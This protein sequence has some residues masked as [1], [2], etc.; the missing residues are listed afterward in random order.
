MNNFFNKKKYW[1]KLV[2]ISVAFFFTVNNFTFALEARPADTL[3]PVS[4]VNPMI[5]LVEEDGILRLVKDTSKRLKPTQA[6]QE[7]W[8]FFYLS[9]YIGQILENYGSEI[10]AKK[11][12]KELEKHISHVEFKRFKWQEITKE[13]KTFRLP[14]RTSSSKKDRHPFLRFYLASDEPRE[15]LGKVSMPIGDTVRMTCENYTL[16]EMYL[17]KL[18]NAIEKN[19]TVE[20]KTGK[21]TSIESYGK[22]AD[23]M[24]PEE[25]EA[26]PPRAFLDKK[27][28]IIATLLPVIYL[29]F[30]FSPQAALTKTIT[31]VLPVVAVSIAIHEFFHWIRI[32]VLKRQNQKIR[33]KPV[34]SK[35]GFYFDLFTDR[36]S[37]A[38]K[39]IQAGMEASGLISTV[40]SVLSLFLSP[41]FIIIMGIVNVV[42]AS[43]ARDRKELRKNVDFVEAH[44]RFYKKVR[45]VRR[46]KAFRKAEKPLLILLGGYFSS[47]KGL[48]SD[49]LKR[50]IERKTKSKV[51]IIGGDN[52]LWREGRRSTE[53]AYPYDKYEVDRWKD[54]VKRLKEGKTAYI[55]YYLSMFGRRLNVRKKDLDEIKS[56]ASVFQRSGYNL[57]YADFVRKMPIGNFLPDRHISAK[58]ARVMDVWKDN[59]EALKQIISLWRETLKRP[60]EEFLI[61]KR[62]RI[63]IDADTGDILEAFTP[64]KEDVLIVEFEQALKYEEIRDQ[65][66]ISGFVEASPL[67]RR[68]FFMARRRSGKRYTKLT[69]E[70]AEEKF[71]MLFA[72]EDQLFTQKGYADLIVKNDV[73]L[74]KK[75]LDFEDEE[76]KLEEEEKTPENLILNLKNS[77]IELFISL[78]PGAEEFKEIFK[79]NEERAIAQFK[80]LFK[81]LKR[82]TQK[83]RKVSMATFEDGA[84]GMTFFVQVSNYSKEKDICEAS[85]HVLDHEIANLFGMPLLEKT[86]K[87]TQVASVQAIRDKYADKEDTSIFD[88]V[89]RLKKQ[90]FKT[91]LIYDNETKVVKTQKGIYHRDIE[92]GE[93]HIYKHAL[94][95]NTIVDEMAEEHGF[96]REERDLLKYLAHEVIANIIEFGEEGVFGIRPV[97]EDGKAVGLEIVAWDIGPGVIDPE[98]I[99]RHKMESLPDADGRF[100]HI[101]E[102]VHQMIVERKEKVWVSKEGRFFED[103]GEGTITTGTKISL[104][105]LREKEEKKEQEV[106]VIQPPAEELET[107]GEATVLKR[108]EA[109]QHMVTL[110]IVN[111]QDMT[112]NQRRLAAKSLERWLATDKARHIPD[113]RKYME[114][115]ECNE[116]EE[117]SYLYF[118]VS[119]DNIEIEALA[120]LGTEE[121]DHSI[122]E[123]APWNRVIAK[124]ERKLRGAGQQLRAFAIRKLI[125]EYG[126]A[127]YKEENIGRVITLGHKEV[128]EGKDVFDYRT[129]DKNAITEYLEVADEEREQFISVYGFKEDPQEE[130]KDGTKALIS[131]LIGLGIGT[132]FMLSKMNV[133]SPDAAKIM[134]N[135]GF[136]GTML[137]MVERRPH[138]KKHHKKTYRKKKHRR[139]RRRPDVTYFDR[140]TGEA[141]EYDRFDRLV[142]AEDFTGN[143]WEEYSYDKNYIKV[144]L[145]NLKTGKMGI[146]LKIP[147]RERPLA[148]C[149]ILVND[150]VAGSLVYA[151]KDHTC[152]NVYIK[153]EM[154]KE[155][156]ALTIF[157]WMAARAK[158]EE[159]E[160][161]INNV[162]SPTISRLAREFIQNP[163]IENEKDPENTVYEVYQ[164][165][166]NPADPDSGEHIADIVL[167]NGRIFDGPFTVTMPD[168]IM[169]V[170]KEGRAMLLDKTTGEEAKEVLLYRTEGEK[171][172][173]EP[174]TFEPYL[175][176]DGSVGYGLEDENEMEIIEIEKDPETG[177]RRIVSGKETEEKRS[178]QDLNGVIIDGYEGGVVEGKISFSC[179]EKS[180]YRILN[181]C[182]DIGR[183]A[184]IVLDDQIDGATITYFVKEAVA[185]AFVHGSMKGKKLDPTKKVKLRYEI[186]PE[187]IKVMVDDEGA[188]EFDPREYLTSSLM[189]QVWLSM[190]SIPKKWLFLLVPDELGPYI[191]KKYGF[192]Q[193][194]YQMGQFFDVVEYTPSFNKKGEKT[195][196]TMKLVYYPKDSKAPALEEKDTPDDIT[197]PP[198]QSF[199]KKLPLILYGALIP[200]FI[201]ALAHGWQDSLLAYW[202]LSVLFA[203]TV[204][205]DGDTKY[206]EIDGTSYQV[207]SAAYR[208]LHDKYRQIPDSVVQIGEADRIFWI[209]VND[210]VFPV[211][212]VN[213]G[214]K[215]FKMYIIKNMSQEMIDGF[216]SELNDHPLTREIWRRCGNRYLYT[217]F[218]LGY[219][220]YQIGKTLELRGSEI[221]FKEETKAIPN[222][223][224]T[225][226]VLKNIIV[227][228]LESTSL[229]KTLNENIKKMGEPFMPSAFVYRGEDSS[230]SV[231]ILSKRPNGTIIPA[232]IRCESGDKGYK[233]TTV[234]VLTY[235]NHRA[236]EKLCSH[237]AADE[238]GVHWR[239]YAD[240]CVSRWRNIEKTIR[241]DLSDMDLAPY[242]QQLFETVCCY[243]QGEEPVLVRILT[244]LASS[245]KT[246]QE[247]LA[248]IE[249]LELS[250]NEEHNSIAK[251]I[252]RL[253]YKKDITDEVD[254]TA[255]KSKS[256]KKIILIKK[257]KSDKGAPARLLEVLAEKKNWKLL[258]KAHGEK[259]ITINE[260]LAH[261]KP[262]SK[263]TVKKEFKVL[264]S[265]GIFVERNENPGYY[266]FSS[267]FKE[268]NLDYIRKFI[269]EVNR[270]EHQVGKRGEKRPL[271]RYEIPREETA[272]VKRIVKE[273]VSSIKKRNRERIRRKLKGTFNRAMGDL[274]LNLCGQRT[275]HIDA[276]D[277]WRVGGYI[278]SLGFSPSSRDFSSMCVILASM[279]ESNQVAP[280]LTLCRESEEFGYD[281]YYD[282]TE[283]KISEHFLRRLASQVFRWAIDN[284]HPVLRKKIKY[285]E[286]KDLTVREYIEFFFLSL[287]GKR[288]RLS[289]HL[290]AVKK[291]RTK[292]EREEAI[293]KTEQILAMLGDSTKY[294]GQDA[295]KRI[296]TLINKAVNAQ[297]SNY[298]SIGAAAALAY[299]SGFQETSSL[300]LAIIIG[301]LI[302][303]PY[304]VFIMLEML[305]VPERFTYNRKPSKLTTQELIEAMKGAQY[306]KMIIRA[307]KGKSRFGGLSGGKN[308]N[309]IWARVEE[310]FKEHPEWAKLS[311]EELVKV[312]PEDILKGFPESQHLGIADQIL[313]MWDFGIRKKIATKYMLENGE[314][315]LDPSDEFLKVLEE[316][317]VKLV[318]K[319]KLAEF[320]DALSEEEP[321]K[322][323]KK[324]APKKKAKTGGKTST[325]NREERFERLHELREKAGLAMGDKKYGKAISLHAEA[326]KMAKRSLA[327][328]KD[329]SYRNRLDNII[330]Y[331]EDRARKA[332]QLDEVES[333][334]SLDKKREEEKTKIEK[335]MIER[336]RREEEERKKEAEAL[337]E[338]KA[339]EERKKLEEEA[340]KEEEKNNLIELIE[341]A[342]VRLELLEKPDFSTTQSIR[343]L[344]EV[345]DAIEALVGYERKHGRDNSVSAKFA[346]LK[347]AI[348]TQERRYKEWKRGR[349]S[350][351]KTITYNPDVLLTRVKRAKEKSSKGEEL[352]PEETLES[353]EMSFEQ[354]KE[355]LIKTLDSGKRFK[356]RDERAFE[357]LKQVQEE[358]DDLSQKKDP[359]STET[360]PDGSPYNILKILDRKFGYI[361]LEDIRRETYGRMPDGHLSESV[362]KRDLATLIDLDLAE[363]KEFGNKTLYN[364]SD[365]SHPDE[366]FIFSVLETLGARPTRKQKEEAKRLLLSE[367]IKEIKSSGKNTNL[368]AGITGNKIKIKLSTLDHPRIGVE[369][370][371][372]ILGYIKNGEIMLTPNA[373]TI[374]KYR[375]H[376][377]LHN[378]YIKLARLLAD[379]GLGNTK[380]DSITRSSFERSGF[381][382]RAPETIQELAR[383]RP[384]SLPVGG[385][386]GA[387]NLSHL[388]AKVEPYL[389]KVSSPE[390]LLDSLPEEIL[391][392]FPGGEESQ[393]MVCAQLMGIGLPGEEKIAGLPVKWI[394]GKEREGS[395]RIAGVQLSHYGDMSFEK[396]LVQET[397]RII[398][399]LQEMKLLGEEK[400]DLVVFPEINLSYYS[401]WEE[402]GHEFV[403]KHIGMIEK[404]SASTGI[405]VAFGVDRVYQDETI[406][407]SNETT[408]KY[409]VID[410]SG[411]TV[412]R[413]EFSKLK[414]DKESRVFDFKG[415]KIGVMICRELDEI[416]FD[417]EMDYKA[418]WTRKRIKEADLILIPAATDKEHSTMWMD[419]VKERIESP[420]IFT[421]R[422]PEVYDDQGSS[423]YL[424][425]GEEHVLRDLE[426]IF[427]VDSAPNKRSA[428]IEYYDEA[429]REYMRENFPQLVE[430]L[431][432]ID[433]T[434]ELLGELFAQRKE[435]IG[436]ATPGMDWIMDFPGET[437]MSY[438]EKKD[439]FFEKF[440]LKWTSFTHSYRRH[441]AVSG[442]EAIALK[443]PGEP[444]CSKDLVEKSNFTVAKRMWDKYGS[445]SGV[446]KP[447][448]I[449]ELPEGEYP[450]YP[451]VGEV[452]TT[453]EKP[454]RIVIY[455]HTDGMRLNAIPQIMGFLQWASG[456]KSAKA[457]VTHIARQVFEISAKIHDIG[458][459][460]ER[461]GADGKP[462]ADLIEGN[463]ILQ[464]NG[465]V[466]FVSDFGAFW[467]KNSDPLSYEARIEDLMGLVRD[468]SSMATEV[469]EEEILK[470]A[471]ETVRAHT[472]EEVYSEVKSVMPMTKEYAREHASEILALHNSIPYTHW[473]EEMLLADIWEKDEE[474]G[475][476]QDRVLHHK[477]DHSFVA[478]DED[479]SPAGILIAYERPGGEM[480]GVNDV[481]L[482]LHSISVKE[483][484]KRKGIGAMLVGKMASS[485][486]R[487]GFRKRWGTKVPLAVS[488][489]TGSDNKDAQAFYEKIGFEK[490]GKKQYDSHEDYVYWAK[491]ETLLSRIEEREA[492][493]ADENPEA[494]I[495]RSKSLNQ[496]TPES[497]VERIVFNGRKLT[498]KKAEERIRRLTKKVNLFN[499]LIEGDT[500]HVGIMEKGKED[501]ESYHRHIPEGPSIENPFT[502]SG[503]FG[504]KEGLMLVFSVRG[505]LNAGGVKAFASVENMM[506]AYNNYIR[507]ARAFIE[508]GISPDTPLDSGTRTCFRGMKSF[509]KEVPETVR[510]LASLELLDA[511]K[512]SSETKE[513]KKREQGK[514]DEPIQEELD[515]S[516]S[517]EADS[518]ED[519]E[520]KEVALEEK[521]PSQIAND[522]IDALIG[523]IESRALAT[524]KRGE[525]LIIGIDTSWIPSVQKNLAST[526]KLLKRIERLSES[527]LKGFENIE[528]CIAD[529][530]GILASEVWNARKAK[531][532]K[533]PLAPLSNVILLGEED[534]LDAESFRAFKGS[535]KEE[536]AFFAKV[537]FPERF[538]GRVPEKV[539]IN[540]IKLITEVLEKVS[541]TR[542][543]KE[544]YIDL[545]DTVAEDLEKLIEEYTK[546][547]EILTKA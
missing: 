124:E 427:M 133:I 509:C 296:R 511:S 421:N 246:P 148:S 52:W 160:L 281:P 156:I 514:K 205:E 43:S 72:Q 169:L 130:S 301:I 542:C 32:L 472:R 462:H 77:D 139:K 505:I 278:K 207:D 372:V 350:L 469:T 172:H 49:N 493:L 373:G 412:K 489:Q 298:Y 288:N 62:S 61:D 532:L 234:T 141:T 30:H 480:Q 495:K 486:K 478:V 188:E 353:I 365:L 517:Y 327:N 211:L 64:E 504:H 307:L 243:L 322:T 273:V 417:K 107:A 330:R 75:V 225:L 376:R 513:E 294:Y 523:W 78:M 241:E 146:R 386:N 397:N 293:S 527:R 252:L 466:K 516:S 321:K 66:D 275:E 543:A 111:A 544:F 264:E 528:V 226:D 285:G 16:T 45:K 482:Y 405:A 267:M 28:I 536:G 175:A 534:A 81:A 31:E 473:T 95:A 470:I 339:E 499:V 336:K 461:I 324:T 253:A 250:E 319:R 458:Y 135:I 134:T 129:I 443:I 451:W 93:E 228:N 442:T 41:S 323:P 176:P 389:S 326:I 283:I 119:G 190:L 235:M 355:T 65:A 216:I 247:A 453:K 51:H 18:W 157:N 92:K 174:V 98:I 424:A 270:I 218:S 136:F 490:V 439:L 158:R 388:T 208:E 126:E 512:G 436:L 483:G 91:L 86:A 55:P 108:D 87:L 428:S 398:Q 341:T 477:W 258:K 180:F 416:F 413:H 441:V 138:K 524:G 178:S 297:N 255:Q 545:P 408:I 48:L 262:Y 414:Y 498:L 363:E 257:K 474:A 446:Q 423:F 68:E 340:K 182:V 110:P 20:L 23:P 276:N 533:E 468:L 333:K 485:L 39:V 358:M 17:D 287:D 394:R 406:L 452:T 420:I 125:E 481:S 347:E 269:A 194:V 209:K 507:I 426:G 161:T 105:Y 14:Y 201:L 400:P 121:M 459:I 345:T 89:L 99:T 153:P 37:S 311:A 383:R 464:K 222:F 200:A 404:V 145:R 431:G 390:E 364:A 59:P 410:P 50:Y 342:Q 282:L 212:A 479:D 245:A 147:R 215:T 419:R 546:R 487:D 433:K 522:F 10:S 467:K 179:T 116:E 79:R 425:K 96:S 19:N 232:L 506:T 152:E 494:Q 314:S 131:V 391:E 491:V 411:D 454:Y 280:T 150:R 83:Q 67:H 192:H 292:Q 384:S 198:G 214:G 1:M 82:K 263:E 196:G 230:V 238:R 71:K 312:L 508:L 170:V 310:F 526:Q 392:L 332:E 289:E 54:A 343:Q 159:K 434:K 393:L 13:G 432:D 403:E 15:A 279:M 90:G 361:S 356:K 195:G 337:K 154:R 53:A 351:E 437:P 29:A 204:T 26:E 115:L 359:D 382:R 88:I 104:V 492:A 277:V 69:Q 291:A 325:K 74:E 168:N 12:K 217:D 173:G 377:K 113:I 220:H 118:V 520:D 183:I 33:Y 460:G 538:D 331:H 58:F 109:L 94:D 4:R 57:L 3:S 35:E 429:S 132:A 335:A 488:L 379:S 385:L 304:A 430:V 318:K 399:V 500:L 85:I 6:F 272:D 519:V 184:G 210:V 97:K 369:G 70:E 537:R 440:G 166:Y 362:V 249:E 444:R 496:T 501:R 76:E 303:V 418:K 422:T 374:A 448:C 122:L 191:R 401:A 540:M 447:I 259:G 219:E 357:T 265:I 229:D 151:L 236:L 457:I 450:S 539:D 502:L 302:T 233:I 120:D 286:A 224:K 260:L 535:E 320:A 101:R 352:L 42:F 344:D 143:V 484:Y 455:E 445:S 306:P 240:Q 295:K 102:L 317:G 256:H 329:K 155:G 531:G 305:K 299:L 378:A 271:W 7:E 100:K 348:K 334:R 284:K 24:L 142:R 9:L 435:M 73:P 261:R 248:N 438:A 8:G 367:K 117:L 497:G 80:D 368:Y 525:K 449:I 206:I 22:E 268:L 213:S 456:G 137:G 503:R 227:L 193:A 202:L 2:A 186:A 315:M 165:D 181:R 415:F 144:K 112:K 237:M 223:G 402:L 274:A 189:E 171:I 354:I 465:K 371:V 387:M 40:C 140:K 309:H 338:K 199:I 300:Q 510:G 395:L 349:K 375:K 11:L 44:K 167:F 27:T 60:V 316:Q 396:G 518:P 128:E 5:S 239:E 463:F 244:Q 164:P 221:L 185:N 242:S 47:G 381:L 127:I 475:R 36:A 38:R 163:A 313:G 266:R 123:A 529:S 34:I 231:L 471:E 162:K 177:E 103:G 290:E 366:E 25:K 56:S 346:E 360:M 521:H 197:R 476:L 370:D 515:V 251:A 149:K 308:L 541:G 254:K 187:H 409:I 547:E 106:E 63:C 380:I 84:T 21:K 407:G 530:P 203:G 328:A 46:S 114:F